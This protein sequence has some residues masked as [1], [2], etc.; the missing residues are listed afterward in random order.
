MERVDVVYA[1]ILDEA[2]EKVLMVQNIKHDNWSMPGGAVEAGE[3]LTEAVIREAREETGL[4]IEAE[5]I[6]AVN[7]AFMERFNHHT[8]FLRLWLRWLAAEFPFKIQ[9]QLRIPH[10]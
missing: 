8:I 10:G 3:T 6:L 7:E 5:D 2:E 4:T 1:L 9:K